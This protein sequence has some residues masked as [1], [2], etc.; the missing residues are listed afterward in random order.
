MKI[1]DKVLTASFA[2]PLE[3]RDLKGISNESVGKHLAKEDAA[4]GFEVL[5]WNGFLKDVID[6]TYKLQD[7]EFDAIV[8]IARGGLVIARLL[9]DLTGVK[10][11][12]SLHAEYYTGP[13]KHYSEPR[14]TG[15]FSQSIEV[16]RIIVV[17]D[18][19]DSGKTM[20]FA[21]SYLQG[22]GFRKP[23]TLSVYLK[24]WSRFTPDYYSRIV[25]RW[26]V[27]PY[28]H[29]ETAMALFRQGYSI[30]DLM[31]IGFEPAVL[32]RLA[33]VVAG[34]KANLEGSEGV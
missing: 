1:I 14:I 32:E 13:N 25:N 2:N 15:E 26:I 29:F 31:K 8:A 22:K 33:R 11:I 30:E 21:L 10:K 17:D 12:Y 28:E 23:L 19:V 9:S 34:R 7:T 6:L 18:V 20:Q 27:F 3:V 24:P 4:L 5:T 16:T